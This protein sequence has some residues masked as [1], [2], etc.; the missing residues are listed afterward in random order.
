MLR[1]LI[2]WSLDNARTVLVL[3]GVLLAASGWLRLQT[4]ADTLSNTE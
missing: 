4:V 1:H 2:A 3:A